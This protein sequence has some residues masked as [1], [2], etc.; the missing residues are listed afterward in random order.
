M[1]TI[2]DS[3]THIHIFFLFTVGNANVGCSG[4]VK[5]TLHNGCVLG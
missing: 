3:G 5:E 1:L 4:V 2:P